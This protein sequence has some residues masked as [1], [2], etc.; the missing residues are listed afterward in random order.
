M[1]DFTILNKTVLLCAK[2]NSGK[3]RLLRYLVLC[4][5]NK[6]DK[7]FVICPTE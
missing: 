4:E 1:E 2:R 7:L 5:K 3:S 6:F